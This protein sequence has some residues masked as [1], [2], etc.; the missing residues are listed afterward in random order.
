[1]LEPGTGQALEIPCNLGAFHDVELVK[2]R[3]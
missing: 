2:Y 1:M 3:E